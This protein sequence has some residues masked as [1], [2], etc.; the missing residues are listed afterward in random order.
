MRGK[1]R[2]KKTTKTRIICVATAVFSLVFVFIAYSIKPKDFSWS[3]LF[4]N[5]GIALFQLF[6]AVLIVNVYFSVEDKKEINRAV[7]ESIK[8][9]IYPFYN[10][11]ILLM[12]KEFGEMGFNKVIAKFTSNYELNDI[13]EE[14]ERV[15]TAI[16]N[17]FNTLREEALTCTSQ[18]SRIAET[19]MVVNNPDFLKYTTYAK[20]CVNQLKVLDIDNHDNYDEIIKNFLILICMIEFILNDL[21]IKD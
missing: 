4:S 2:L 9:E 10:R 12:R 17:E 8:I 16:K 5:L 6:L 14:K 19:G 18:L 1:D 11:F 20:R 13:Y 3:D 15:I 21:K 7:F